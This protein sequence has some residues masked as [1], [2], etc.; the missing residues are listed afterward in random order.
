LP[1]QLPAESTQ[2]AAQVLVAPLSD[3]VAWSVPR[4]AWEELRK[5][6]RLSGEVFR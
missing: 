1:L 4:G 2:L 6:R 3:C 5:A